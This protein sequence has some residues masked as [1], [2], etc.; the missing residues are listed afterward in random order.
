M[1][2]SS[3]THADLTQLKNQYSGERIFVIGNGP[4]LSET[5]L[6]QLDSE[7]TFALNRVNLIYDDVDWRPDF[8]LFLNNLPCCESDQRAV[9]SV[10]E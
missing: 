3:D 8:Y 6:E 7:Y 9:Q 2:T 1:T 5:P 10:C 4:S